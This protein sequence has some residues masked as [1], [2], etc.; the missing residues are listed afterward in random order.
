MSF[1]NVTFLWGLLALSIPIIVHLFNFRKAKVVQFSNVRF[2]HQVRKK[3]SSKLQLKQLL[4]LLCR[5][6][7]IAFL[8]LAFAQPFIP[9]QEE[10]LNSSSVILYVDNS[11]SM[12]NLNQENTAALTSAKSMA[13]QLIDLYPTATQFKILDNDFGSQSYHFKSAQKA[14]DIVAEMD[15]SPVSRTGQEV[16]DKIMALKDEGQE[17]EIF[18]ISD[19]QRSTFGQLDQVADSSSQ[20]YYLPI[21]TLQSNNLSVDSVYLNHPFVLAHNDNVLTA[22]IK[23][24]GNSSI[25]DL[26]VKLQLNGKQFA[27][28]AI[29]IDAQSTKSIPFELSNQL[30]QYNEG[31]ISFEDF[32]VTFDNDF[33]LSFN[34]APKIKVTEIKSTSEKT[35]IQKVF[36]DNALFE[37]QSF[38]SGQIDYQVLEGSDLLIFNALDEINNSLNAQVANLLS[39]KKSVL[40]IPHPQERLDEIKQVGLLN[41]QNISSQEKIE[42]KA[43]DLENPFFAGIFESLDQNTALPMAAPLFKI[44][45]L[46]QSLLELK[47]GQSLLSKISG[48]GNLYVLSTPLITE[49]TNFFRHAFFVPT[50]QRIAELSASSSNRLYYTAD[51]SNISITLDSINHQK[52]YE[53]T[54]YSHEGNALIP[55]QRLVQNQ[56]VM[57]FPKYLL[58]PGNYQLKSDQQTLGFVSFNQAPEESQLET[59]DSEEFEALYAG[60]ENMERFEKLNS[61]NFSQTMKEKYHSIE[62]WK[63]ALL[64]SV[65]FLIAESLL[66]RFL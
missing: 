57:D 50:M 59:L 13:G 58:K 63:Y 19:G 10:G 65:V 44:A 66:L 6:L 11:G 41:Y 35:Y 16:I 7:F 38:A 62:L 46:Q 18:L 9:G 42:L 64:L 55:S 60:L 61:Q 54:P 37:F 12:N 48:Q 33:Y 29:N 28:V 26:I 52:L 8:V 49:Q 47:T 27:S 2:L 15:Y 45:G 51:H 39:R 40:L 32:P 43:P 25:E 22:R 17:S 21:S 31:K 3:S 53:L 20:Y 1:A 36:E 24:S 14:K 30:Q 56:L 5:L 23:N 4:V 34:L